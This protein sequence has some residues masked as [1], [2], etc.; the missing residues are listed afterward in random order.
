[1]TELKA[2][3]L[4][5]SHDVLWISDAARRIGDRAHAVELETQLLA[6]GRLPIGRLAPLLEEIA[7][8][9]GAQVALELAETAADY[10][11]ERNFLESAVWI[12]ALAGDADAAVH[13]DELRV[14][15]WPPTSEP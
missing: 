5:V 11:L 9:R 15:A 4:A 12:A 7:E 2:L 1:M 3:E 13:W 14:T 6:E 8:F 10:T